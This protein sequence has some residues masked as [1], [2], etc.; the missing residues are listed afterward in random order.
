MACDFIKSNDDLASC[1]LN[2]C[3]W[4]EINPVSFD[5]INDFKHIFD[6][7]T[8]EYSAVYAKPVGDFINF[9]KLFDLFCNIYTIHFRGLED[10]IKAPFG[11]ELPPNINEYTRGIT[12]SGFLNRFHDYFTD[13]VEDSYGKYIVSYSYDKRSLQ[14]FIDELTSHQK[15]SI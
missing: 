3:E 10:N 14:G 5:S 8:G 15:V 13:R 1:L 12:F 7:F 2:E 6:A 9:E 4:M 11:D